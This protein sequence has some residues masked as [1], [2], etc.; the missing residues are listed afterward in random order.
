MSPFEYSMQESCCQSCQKN[1][2]SFFLSYYTK[3]IVLG[4]EVG[5]VWCAYHLDGLVRR[6][7]GDAVVADELGLLV[8]PVAVENVAFLADY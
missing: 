5:V 4:Y 3:A 8:V 2:L 6:E 7:K 1:T